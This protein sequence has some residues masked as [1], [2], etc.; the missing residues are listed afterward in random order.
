MSLYLITLLNNLNVLSLLVVLIS[1]PVIAATFIHPELGK[2]RRK[3][4]FSLGVAM[5]V[6]S[7]LWIVFA[8]NNSLLR[9]WA[10]EYNYDNI[11]ITCPTCKD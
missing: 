11:E 9:E 6:S 1:I 8:P 3:L 4:L 5:A 7:L 10:K 2:R